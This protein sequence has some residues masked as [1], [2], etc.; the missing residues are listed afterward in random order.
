MI[1]EAQLTREQ[2]VRLAILFHFQRK[3]FY[4]FAITA[5]VVTAYAMIQAVPALLAVVWL[6]F[7]FSI[8]IGIFGAYKEARDPNNPVFKP[9]RYKFTA[10]GVAVGNPDHDSQLSWDHFS[11]WNVIASMYVLKLKNGQILAVPQSSVSSTQAPKLRALLDAH[12]KR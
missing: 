8:G 10:S 1:I 3:Q 7:L 4:F 6:P 2:F 5:A 9:T 11:G 12:L